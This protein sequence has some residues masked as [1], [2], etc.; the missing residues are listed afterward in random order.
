M[1]QLITLFLNNLIPI[2]LAATVGFLLRKWLQL[3]SKTFSQIIFYILSPC[4]VFQLLTHSQLANSEILHTMLFALLLAALMGGL[5]WIL[6]KVLH[7]NRQLM[8]AVLITCV[9]MNG[10]NYG[11]PLTQFAFGD[12]ALAFASL[13]FVVMSMLTNTVGVVIASSGT[14]TILQ[15]LKGL[16]KL[17]A[18]YSLT[19]ALIFIHFK[20]IMPTPIDRTIA[21]LGD[22]AIPC[23]LILLGMQLVNIHWDGQ[24]L[25]LSFVTGMRLL[26]SP[27]IAFGLS[28]LFGLSGAA[29]Q[30]VVLEA[31][32][33]VAVMTTVLATQFDTLPTFVTATVLVTTLLSPIT[34]TPLL[35]IL[36]A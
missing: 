31:A 27:L 2:L 35:A 1:I 19:L 4:L 29:H 13:F 34:L 3:D 18:T 28:R 15:S 36:G 9:F 5:T 26:V 16:L 12:A 24:T 20:W 23:M 33:P 14:Q 17:P 10:G 21:M 6:A 22:A 32:M 7:F 8:A 25:A 11:L 30:A